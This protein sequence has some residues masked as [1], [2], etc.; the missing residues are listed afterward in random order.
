MFPGRTLIFPSQISS[1]HFGEKLSSSA[2]RGKLT[3]LPRE[4]VELV[5]RWFV[6]HSLWCHRKRRQ[7]GN[8]FA[9][10]AIYLDAKFLFFF[11]LCKIPFF[12]YSAKFLF[13][14]YSA[15]IR[16]F[17]SGQIFEGKSY[18]QLYDLYMEIYGIYF[19]FIGNIFFSFQN[20]F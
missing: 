16:V 2:R 3:R 15:Y 17:N 13:F 4:E 18:P 12:L 8:I 7:I 10:L 14:S 9:L 19:N 5:R 1:R 20:I 11:L 6:R